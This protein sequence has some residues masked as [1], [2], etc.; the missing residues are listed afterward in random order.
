MAEERQVYETDTKEQSREVTELKFKL[1]AEKI[2]RAELRAENRSIQ[3][4]LRAMEQSLVE[5]KGYI[6][7]LQEYS[8]RQTMQYERTL[9]DLWEDKEGWKAQCL[10]RKL[11]I[12]HT[13]KQ[14]YKAI[15]K[16]HEILEKAEV[17]HQSF[18]P[19]GR[20]EQQLLNFIEE[21]RNH[22]EQV[23]AFYGYNYNMLN[24]V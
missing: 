22:C 18:S 6:I 19:T 14:I 8:I 1:R 10:A 20:N 17:L 12:K 7:E 5:H 16:A 4:A 23:K 24:N 9:A 11:Y 2:G 15:R 21:V 13:I 3:N